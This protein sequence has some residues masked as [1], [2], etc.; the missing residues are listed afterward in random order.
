LRDRRRWRHWL[1]EAKKRFNLCVL[2]YIVTANHI[3][4]L[5]RDRGDGEVARS[6]QLVAGRTA[7][8]YN[9]RK[10]RKGAYW[11]DRYHAT[12]IDTQAHLAR[13][14]V[15]IDMNMV[16]AGV[17]S[18]PGEWSDAGY[19]EIKAPPKRYAIIDRVASVELLGSKTM[20]EFQATRAQWVAAELQAGRYE[21]VEAGSESLAVG[22]EAFVQA[23]QASP[24]VS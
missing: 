7:Q 8:K 19:A 1:F 6:M 18:H 23:V 11:E 24:H 16:R 20:A 15:Y 5:V 13:F 12:T 14:L 22:S 2:N 21:R 10:G 4:L 3:H 17:L 9:L